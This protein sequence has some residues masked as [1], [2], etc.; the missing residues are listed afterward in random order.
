MRTL[1]LFFHTSTHEVQRLPPLPPPPR[2]ICVPTVCFVVLQVSAYT[3]TSYTQGTFIINNYC[4]LY[5]HDPRV[6]WRIKNAA[7]FKKRFIIFFLFLISFYKQYIIILLTDINYF[8]VHIVVCLRRRTTKTGINSRPYTQV[9]D[10]KGRG[11]YSFNHFRKNWRLPATHVLFYELYL[12]LSVFNF[13]W[14]WRLS[15]S[16]CIMFKNGKIDFPDYQQFFAS[17]TKMLEISEHRFSRK[18]ITNYLVKTL[19]THVNRFWMGTSLSSSLYYRDKWVF[20]RYIH[21]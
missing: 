6:D 19:Q 11:L 3:H 16:R 7:F 8:P 5:M 15:L 21:E 17:T 14:F 13:Y 9:F 2:G 12:Y 10:F 4:L 20:V 1:R 18:R